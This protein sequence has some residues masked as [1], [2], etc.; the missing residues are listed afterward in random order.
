MNRSVFCVAAVLVALM[1]MSPVRADEADDVAAA[2]L[3]YKLGTRAFDLGHYDEA[4]KEYEAAYEAKDDPALLFNIGQAYRL[5]GD[6]AA[7]LRAYKSYLHRV[8]DAENAEE[9]RSRIA[10]LQKLA[11]QAATAQRKPPEGTKQPGPPIVVNQQP[12]QRT[13]TAAKSTPEKPPRPFYKRWYFWTA[14]GLVAVGGVAVALALT[15]PA[16][17]DGFNSTL[18][19]VGP[20]IQSALGIHF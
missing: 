8:P 4:V 7:A 9:V 5:K 19:D 14:I 3:H 11:D 17:S 12:T 16:H 1:A 2:R 20:G 6:F 18:P 15:L 13:S 10:E